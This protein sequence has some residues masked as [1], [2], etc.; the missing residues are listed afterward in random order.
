MNNYSHPN[1]ISC[2]NIHFKWG[3]RTYIMGVINVTPDS[4]SHDGL[5]YDIASAEAQAIRFMNEGVDILD[6]GGESTR[7]DFNPVPV[8]EE[9]HRVIPVIERLAKI[10]NIP[11]SIDTYK[12]EVARQA[13]LAGASIVNDVWG[14]QRDPLLAHLAAE[15]NAPLIIVQN[16]R[17][18]SFFNVMPELISSLHSSIDYALKAGVNPDNI[19]VD[20]G[21][22]FGKTVEQNLEIINRLDE[23][24]LLGRPVLLGTSRKSTIGAVLNLPVDQRLEGTAATIAIGIARGADIIRIHDVPQMIRVIKMSDAI[25][26]NNSRES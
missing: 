20:P 18:G 8:N 22:G 2:G 6:I 24:K 16:Q 10:V 21:F 14:L 26:R 1:P 11:I 17:G 9:L 4:F 3:E 13:L 7:P 25:V 15:K 5:D 19:I 12:S 23:L